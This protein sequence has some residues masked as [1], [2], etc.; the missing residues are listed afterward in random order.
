MKGRINYDKNNAANV[1]IKIEMSKRNWIQVTSTAGGTDSCMRTGN[2][3]CKPA[4][5]NIA[6]VEGN[7][8]INSTVRSPSPAF[9]YRR[10][11]M[12]TQELDVF[13]T[14]NNGMI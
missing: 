6:G 7:T 4:A 8:M 11:K 14:L 9:W 13:P 2:T 3:K 5:S 10:L 1:A 12:Q